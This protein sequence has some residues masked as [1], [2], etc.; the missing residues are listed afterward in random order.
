MPVTP[1]YPGVYI[2]ELPS[3]VR[4][5]IGV[6]TSITAFVG[7]ALRGPV[8]EPVLIH[9]YGD[10]E[11]TFGGL[12]TKS[13]MSYQVRQ[14]FLNG[15]SDA[16][17]VRTVGASG[18]LAALYAA[19]APAGTLTISA[20]SPGAWGNSVKISVDKTNLI[21]MADADLFHLYVTEVD[22]TDT[23]KTVKYEPFYNVSVNPVSPRYIVKVL[24][25]E[26]TLVRA[27][28]TIPA[29]APNALA[30]TFLASG[31]DG[32]VLTATEVIGNSGNKTGMYALEKADLFNILCLPPTL[33]G[34]DVLVDIDTASWG[35]AQTYCKKRR[36]V[37]LID[38]PAAWDT[39]AEVYNTPGFTSLSIAD[40]NSAFYWPW[41]VV[42][43][44]LKGN[45]PLSIAP[46]GTVAGVI[47]RTD[48]DRGI[49]KAPA[50]I[51]ANLVGVQ[52][53]AVKVTDAENG[54]LNPLGVNVLRTLPAAGNVVW[55]ARTTKGADRLASDWKYLPVR[56]LA[57]YIEESLYRGT[58]WVVFEPNDESLW[59]QI[60]LNVGAFMH[61]LF[62]QGAFQGAKPSESYFVKCDK[63]TTTQNDINQGVVNVIVGFAP[64]KPAE[65]VIIKLQQIAG[66]IVA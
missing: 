41:V 11:R 57:L 55:G 36:A 14:Y 16:I 38:P 62:R 24:E 48:A 56:R 58:Q 51:D 39:L 6:G 8:D 64:L 35:A 45:Q 43:D 37:V 33:N 22:P 34:S 15:G 49:W 30:Y 12:W 4:T 3:G 7:R 31:A 27:T 1:T 59:A 9:S 17:I 18:T 54:Q 2:E 60:R 28:G 13:T 47:A 23:T 40:E 10:F 44:P 20:V 66:Q 32:A 50:G 26:S 42:S 65:F 21:D 5:L 63:E 61:Q 25:N 52:S 29:D 46:C 19:P 53:L